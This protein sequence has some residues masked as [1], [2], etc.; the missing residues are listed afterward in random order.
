MAR[1]KSEM[2]APSSLAPAILVHLRSRGVEPSSLASRFGLTAGDADKDE[3]LLAPSTLSELFEAAAEILGEPFLG[4][5]LPAEVPSRVQGL[6]EAAARSSPT[7]KGALERVARY[8]PLIHPDLEGA[9]EDDGDEL[10]WIERTPRRARGVSRHVHEYGLAFVL[11]VLRVGGCDGRARRVW[12]AH[13][14]PHEIGPL[15]AFFR[16]DDLSFGALDS[17]V[18][19]DASLSASPM[20]S[21]DPRLLAA[22]GPL[23]E[24]ALR[25]QSKGRSFADTLASRL[26]ALLPDR[27]TLEGAADAFHMSPRT[28]QR[29]LDQ[30]GVRFSDLLDRVREELARGWLAE[31]RASLADVAARLG[32]SELATFSRAFK[33][34]TGMPPGM[35]RRRDA[36]FT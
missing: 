31:E 29:R 19:F 4:L 36:R 16:T 34:W 2:P 23:V 15:Q 13:P 24:E 21:S 7:A 22:V 30:E 11:T 35:W 5:R 3:V 25:S 27:A 6:V 20:K 10:R 32:F 1:P 14:R 8:A 9:V 12:F 18:S 17:G 33:R 26:P 28:M